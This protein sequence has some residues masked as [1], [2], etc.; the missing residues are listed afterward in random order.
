VG[1]LS[2]LAGLVSFGATIIREVATGLTPHDQGRSF[3]FM[4]AQ[5]RA[6]IDSLRQQMNE[7][8]LINDFGAEIESVRQMHLANGS[9]VGAQ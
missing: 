5:Q 8:K 9:R 3:M 2:T 4:I 7:E 6:I 1:D